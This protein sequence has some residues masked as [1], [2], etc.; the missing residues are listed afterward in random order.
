MHKGRAA[1]SKRAVSYFSFYSF[2][3]SNLHN[4][5]FRSPLVA[6]RKEERPLAVKILKE[7]AKRKQ[8]DV[9]VMVSTILK[10]Q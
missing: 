5:N 6:L 3:A 2:F 8:K 4:F 10:I 1:D 7:K 9:E